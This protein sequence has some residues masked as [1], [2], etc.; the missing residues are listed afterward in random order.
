M[1]SLSM[2]PQTPAVRQERE[3]IEATSKL[4]SYNLRR[5][6]SPISPIQIRLTKDKLSLISE[7]LQSSEDAHR[8]PDLLLDL[9]AKLGHRGDKVAEVKVMA[10]VLES[11]IRQGEKRAAV[12]VA[13]RII[14]TTESLR[15]TKSNPDAFAEASQVAW[16]A[17][18]RAID[19]ASHDMA[20]QIKMDVLAQTLLLCPPSAISQ[21]MV[22]WRA[23]EEERNRQPAKPTLSRLN[24][25]A[26]SPLSPSS[27]SPLNS[28]I[29]LGQA[30]ASS[31]LGR[32][33]SPA[34]LS[35]A[36]ALDSLM[37]GR[38]GGVRDRLQ[39]GMTSGLRWLVEG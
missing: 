26:S 15:A 38:E 22:S 10:M 20:P 24:T 6:G 33:D 2:A 13:Q 8:H 28:A 11:H 18:Q 39:T 12:E 1:S 30:A 34:T 31:Y 4:A 14:Q 29:Q 35:P 17:C 27:P 16:Q 36:S 25:S 3:F 9:S 21:L 23:A 5:D 32:P 37:H 19:A 7:L